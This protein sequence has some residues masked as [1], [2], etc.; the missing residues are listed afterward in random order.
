MIAITLGTRPEIIK[1][2]SVIRAAEQAG[3]PYYI[4]H[5][6]QH[7]SDKM[8]RVF[9]DELELPQPRYNLGIGSGSHGAQTGAML[10]AMEP[11]FEETRPSVVLV[12]GDTNTVLAGGLVA[13]KLGIK[14][15]HVEAG[16]R[17]Y[18]RTM[19]EEVNRVVTDH[20]SDYLFSPTK[21]STDLLKR[22]GIDPEKIFQVG[23]TVVD[24]VLQNKHL[25]ERKTQILHELG[26]TPKQYLLITMHRPA[27]V[28][29]EETLRGIIDG[30]TRVGERMQLPILFPAH[31]RTKKQLEQFKIHL[32]DTIRLIEP[33]GYLDFL[34]LQQQAA[35]ILTDSGG[36]QEEACI[37]GVPTVTIRD[38]TE[39][40]ETVEVGANR[41]AGTT[42]QGIVAAASEMLGKN[43][44]WQNP[45]GDGT[46][47]EQIIQVV[48]G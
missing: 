29:H 4:L 39:R 2:C 22:E 38:N 11:I 10:A 41:L 23:N 19:P 15:G 13:S 6:N 16:L 30:I 34:Q 33:V 45:F 43:P 31:P 40:P 17:S 47:G 27:N 5:T 12:Q 8:D 20:L 48:T 36:I 37:L 44:D 46:A 26:V 7:Y 35:L 25:A 21:T 42:S 3:V 14:V 9:F 1:M 18:D 28:D 32:P 24:A